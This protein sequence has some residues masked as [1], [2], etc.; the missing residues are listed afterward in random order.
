[1]CV[2]LFCINN[3]SFVVVICKYVLL[4][5]NVKNKQHLCVQC[6]YLSSIVDNI[7]LLETGSDMCLFLGGGLTGVHLFWSKGTGS[8][9]LSVGLP[10][11]K[12]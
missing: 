3:N 6:V 4:S 10:S 9:N 1:M 2:D 12:C 7:D 8:G 11:G 5:D